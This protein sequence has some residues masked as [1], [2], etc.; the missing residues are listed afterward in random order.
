M[1]SPFT[2]KTMELVRKEEVFPFRGEEFT[3]IAHFY[4]CSDTKE[5]VTTDALDTI[6]L[7]QL[8]N[9]YRDKY[10]IPF[11]QEII[12]LRKKYKVSQASMSE[13]LG[14]GANTYNKYEKGEVPS[15]SNGKI[16]QLINHTKEFRRLVNLAE[17]L[18]PKAKNKILKHLDS[19]EQKT[20]QEVIDPLYSI[21]KPKI[22]Q[23][24]SLKMGYQVLAWEKIIQMIRYF[25]QIQPYTT[26]LNK[27]LFYADFGHYKRTGF[28]IS[29]IPYR[30]IALGPVPTFYANMYEYLVHT[31][32][33]AMRS[34]V[35][36]HIGEQ[37]YATEEL[38]FDKQV[39]TPLEY[40]IL[41][42]TL[43]KFKNISTKEIIDLSHEEQAWTAHQAANQ[44]I[45]YNHAFYL[46]HL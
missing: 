38:P 23:Q 42:K 7:N 26:K 19:L 14:F 34:V 11:T 25:S 5:E 40:K 46:K 20:E 8:Y 36:N 32:Q 1:K 3:V 45:D 10:N 37:Y 30:A 17:T 15:R 33:I 31:K 21:K 24:P 27:L 16:L 28:S 29:G 22:N 18:E 4:Y 2:G 35:T 43:E 9:Q 12:A 44:L 6:T 41:K 39:F 13:I